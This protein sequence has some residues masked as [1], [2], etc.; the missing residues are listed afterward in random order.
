VPSAT[1]VEAQ[2]AC[3]GERVEHR[4]AGKEAE[5]KRPWIVDRLVEGREGRERDGRPEP[6][7]ETQR[8][9]EEPAPPDERDSTVVEVE[10]RPGGDGR[11]QEE[12]DRRGDLKARVLA[13]EQD[14]GSCERVQAEESG[15]ADEGDRQAEYSCVA[16]PRGRFASEERERAG[17]DTGEEDE[18]EVRRLVLPVEIQAWPGEQERESRERR[19][20]QD[21][22]RRD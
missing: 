3:R 17:D 8:G 1:S 20:E 2:I 18:P 5:E 22:Q 16:T 6:E 7:D 21:R 13:R 4:A 19:G 12:P 15:G 11:G 9:I 14:T 10:S